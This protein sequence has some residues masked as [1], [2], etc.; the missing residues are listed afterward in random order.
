VHRLLHTLAAR[1]L[2][3]QATGDGSWLLR[4]DVRRLSDGYLPTDRLVHIAA[5]EL[6]RM[7]PQRPVAQRL[8]DLRS[9]HDDDPGEYAPVQPPVD[10]PR[11]GRATADDA[12]S[13]L[14]RATLAGSDPGTRAM[15]LQLVD[16]L[17]GAEPH[18]PEAVAAL[19]EDFRR[20]GYA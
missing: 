5:V 14:G 18:R 6:G 3:V 20:R 7:L 1:D 15:M 11:H 12:G 19:V 8:R 13:A 17:P 4:P 9:R 16:A 10:S 2:V